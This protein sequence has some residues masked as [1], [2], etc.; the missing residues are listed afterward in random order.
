MV[1]TITAQTQLA[2]QCALVDAGGYGI[3]SGGTGDHYPN[4][5]RAGTIRF[6]AV[7][8]VKGACA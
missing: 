8:I 2:P 4:F 3:A 5:D 6:R 7:L 1:Y